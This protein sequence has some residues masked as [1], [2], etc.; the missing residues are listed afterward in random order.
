MARYGNR[1]PEC[2]S[3]MMWWQIEEAFYCIRC[4]KWFKKGVWR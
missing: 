2:K 3:Y 4:H 1:C